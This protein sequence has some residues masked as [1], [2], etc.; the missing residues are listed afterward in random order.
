LG[1]I[2]RNDP[3]PCGS[4]KKCKRCH[5]DANATAARL[6]SVG[7][8]P[9]VSSPLEVQL[10]ATVRALY[11]KPA[12]PVVYHYT[13]FESAYAILKYREIW[14]TAH[15]CT[16]D[17]GELTAAN[18]AILDVA[19][20]LG[21]TRHGLTAEVVQFFARHYND[22]QVGQQSTAY[23]TCFSRERDNANM[24]ARYGDAGRGLCLGTHSR[25]SPCRT[26]RIGIGL[27]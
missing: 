1:K 27:G 19:R 20:T 6:K 26:C 4:G 10:D 12:D 5:L 9:S 3:C 2:S 21:T 14:A 13:S 25:R 18:V 11:G 22:Q 16:N 17:P 15:H 7:Y 24:W 8:A 23:L